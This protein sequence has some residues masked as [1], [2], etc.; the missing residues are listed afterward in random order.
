MFVDEVGMPSECL[1]YAFG[2]ASVAA[3]A[4]VFLAFLVSMGVA[5]EFCDGLVQVLRE[6][7]EASFGG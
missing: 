3:A 4:V 2:V 7:W 6:R 1:R 5:D